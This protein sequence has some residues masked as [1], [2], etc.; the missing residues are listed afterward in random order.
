MSASLL[1]LQCFQSKGNIADIHKRG[2]VYIYIFLYTYIY[3]YIYIYR[4]YV[5]DIWGIKGNYMALGFRVQ[6]RVAVHKRHRIPSGLCQSS[7][8]P[9]TEELL[10]S[11][12]DML[13]I[14]EKGL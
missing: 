9:I 8:G 3:V 1:Y 10:C 5:R 12:L 4:G 2:C 11:F 7:S 14:F 13:S 6:L